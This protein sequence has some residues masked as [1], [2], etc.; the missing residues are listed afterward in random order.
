MAQPT[1]SLPEAFRDLLL[2][3]NTAV[4]TTL[5][6]DGSPQGS[7]VWYWSD[8]GRD[9]QISTTAD[10]LKHRNVLRDNR[11]SVTIVDPARPLRYLEVRGTAD[12]EDDPDGVVRDRIAVK[13]GFSDGAAFDEPGARRV[14]LRI[15]PTRIIEH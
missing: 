15:R 14:T 11:V 8:D 6:A 13:H 12:I 3:A 2:G 5:L 4:L 10:R 1:P 7:P 9:L